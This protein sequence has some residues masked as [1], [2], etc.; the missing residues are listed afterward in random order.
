MMPWFDANGSF[1]PL[2]G[3]WHIFT[4]YVHRPNSRDEDMIIEMPCLRALWIKLVQIQNGKHGPLPYVI[5]NQAFILHWHLAAI[6]VI[7]HL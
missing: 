4:L 6:Q 2:G 3:F 7:F 1:K 5:H